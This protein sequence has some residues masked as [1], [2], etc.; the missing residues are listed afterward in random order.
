M[1]ALPAEAID[2]FDNVCKF[3][4]IGRVPPLICAAAISQALEVATAHD[5][6]FADSGQV[7]FVDF[8]LFQKPIWPH[9]RVETA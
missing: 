7:I 8:R 1:S 3:L 6:L 2:D 9:C 4:A 5:D